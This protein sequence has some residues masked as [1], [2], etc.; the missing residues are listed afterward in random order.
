MFRDLRRIFDQ[1]TIEACG[2]V[3]KDGSLL[4]VDNVAKNPEENFQVS[5]EDL[6]LYEAQAVA[7]WHTHLNGTCNLSVEDYMCFLVFPQLEHY[8]Y[9]GG[10]LATYT[11]QDNLILL[12]KVQTL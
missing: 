4:Q 1:S 7:T 9:D 11:V 2:F 6:D 3:L 5:E 8:I 10:R 12:K